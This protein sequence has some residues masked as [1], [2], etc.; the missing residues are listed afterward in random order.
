ML[1]ST[2]PKGVLSLWCSLCTRN[3]RARKRIREAGAHVALRLSTEAATRLRRRR[4]QR[5]R[6]ATERVPTA[7]RM[8]VRYSTTKRR[9][10]AAGRPCVLQ[11][12]RH[13]TATSASA[14]REGVGLLVLVGRLG[15]ALRRLQSAQDATPRLREVLIL[16]A[17]CCSAALAT[18]GI[19]SPILLCIMWRS[20]R[21]KCVLQQTPGL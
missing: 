16:T 20:Q 4:W 13:S 18:K 6:S 1:R 21:G 11:S 9:V 14:A 7:I 2:S 15:M 12:R 5:L 19:G 10:V 8:C 17:E 3:A